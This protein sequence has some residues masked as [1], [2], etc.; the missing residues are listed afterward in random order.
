MFVSEIWAKRRFKIFWVEMVKN[1]YGQSG[2]RTL[3]LAILQEWI[4]VMNWFFTYYCKFRKVKS[5]FDGR[6]QKYARP[7]SSWDPK[8]CCSSRISVWI[9]LIFCMLNMMQ[10][11][12]V[13][14]TLQSIS[15]TSKC[16]STAVIR[17]GPPVVA[18]RVLWNRVC[19]P[20]NLPSYFLGIG[21]LRF[22][23]FRHGA[24]NSC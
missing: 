12:F 16:K 20:S 18:R 9:E 11:F 5:C 14:P 1:G 15:L 19:L 2:H 10:L 7:T 17:V 24:K 22:S 23:A 21:S 3:K 8:I 4:D 6:G 13:R